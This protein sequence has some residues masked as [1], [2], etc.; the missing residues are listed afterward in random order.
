MTSTKISFIQLFG[1][2]CSGTNYTAQ[3]L[4]N[5][6]HEIQLTQQYGFKHRFHNDNVAGSDNCLFL[7]VYRDAFDWLRSFH[8][9]PFHAA[10][11][12]RN[13]SFAEFIRK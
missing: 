6:F 4:I 10:P 9:Q 3:L 8:L 1:E 11:E 13:I 2:R 7:I 12:L 5:N